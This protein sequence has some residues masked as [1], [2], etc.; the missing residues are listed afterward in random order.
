[1]LQGKLKDYLKKHKIVARHINS[2]AAPN[3]FPVG[4]RAVYV[5]YLQGDSTLS[6]FHKWKLSTF[7]M[8]MEHLEELEA[9]NCTNGC[10]GCDCK[11]KD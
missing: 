6:G 4:R 5:L 3:P 1:M 7:F 9:K 8:D 2:G 10:S 11:A